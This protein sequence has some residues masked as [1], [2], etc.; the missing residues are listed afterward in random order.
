MEGAET[1]SVL[2]ESSVLSGRSSAILKN[3]N[4]SILMTSLEGIR[5]NPWPSENPGDSRQSMELEVLGRAMAPTTVEE[6]PENREGGGTAPV[7][8]AG[9]PNEARMAGL[10]IRPNEGRE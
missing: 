7:L 10:G 6:L 5:G 4:C 8:T 2:R 9:S 3:S 1:A